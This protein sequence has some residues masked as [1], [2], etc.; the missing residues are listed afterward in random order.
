MGGAWQFVI[1]QRQSP[2]LW[3]SEESSDAPKVHCGGDYARRSDVAPE[4]DLRPNRASDVAETKRP[5][6][7]RTTTTS[8]SP[9]TGAPVPQPRRQ[10]RRLIP[11]QGIYVPELRTLR[12]GDSAR[13]G[14]CCGGTTKLP[15]VRTL[16]LLAIGEG[17]AGVFVGIT[18]EVQN[19]SRHNSA[20]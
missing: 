13:C 20:A 5:I 18:L 3:S 9:T 14:I 11:P 4:I 8:A 10:L 2:A 15:T 16:R 6:A 19:P 17:A 1:Q 7:R 12:R